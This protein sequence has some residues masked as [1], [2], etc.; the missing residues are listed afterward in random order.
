MRL[1]A[2]IIFIGMAALP[3]L[4]QAQTDC[5]I[6]SAGEDHW[7]VAA[8][9]SVGLASATL[10]PM[11]K[12]LDDWK[13]SNVHAVLV[14]RHG[15]LVFEHYFSGPD[16]HWGRPV[17]EV[18]FGPDIK[19]DER[20]VTKSIV[21]LVLGIAIDRGLIKSLDEPVLSFFPRLCGS[22]DTGER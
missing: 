3:K 11:V 12:W 13:Q 16:E 4:A 8:P 9:E 7:A 18:A 10:C 17:G 6:P 2:L 15:T 22:A 14:M 5:S 19:H 1:L 20:S 21:G